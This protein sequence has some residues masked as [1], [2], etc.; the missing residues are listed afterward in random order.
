MSKRFPDIAQSMLRFFPP[1]LTLSHCVTSL[2]RFVLPNCFYGHFL[3][4]KLFY[5]HRTQTIKVLCIFIDP[6]GG[7]SK[8]QACNYDYIDH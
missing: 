1:F 3:C 7:E 8:N 2:S 4:H 6:F 5:G